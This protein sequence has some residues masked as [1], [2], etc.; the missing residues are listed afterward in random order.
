M[1]DHPFGESP[2]RNAP[3]PLSTALYE[4]YQGGRSGALRV[5][6]EDRPGARIL[7]RRGRV[8][9]VE[10][11]DTSPTAIV[12]LLRRTG[13]L[14]EA[15][16][17]VAQRFARKRGESLDEAAV[18][19]GLVSAGTLNNIREQVQ[20]ETVLDLMLARDVDVDPDWGEGAGAGRELCT[21]PIPFLLKEAQRRASE[22]GPIRRVVPSMETLFVRSA[23]LEGLRES[24]ENLGMSPAE[25]QVYFF[26]DGQRTVEDLATVTCQSRFAVTRALAALIQTG[27]IQQRISTGPVGP[28]RTGRSVLVRIGAMVVATGALVLLVLSLAGST[29]SLWSHAAAQRTFDDPFRT[30]QDEASRARLV[31]AIRLYDLMYRNRPGSFQDL[32]DDGLVAPSDARAAATFA[33]DGDYLLQEAAA[34]SAASPAPPQE[35]DVEDDR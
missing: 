28:A 17:A 14:D 21:L 3:P 16:I 12:D 23:D 31:G 1:N 18:S 30:L 15:G 29:A 27:H 6:R 4:A 13:L 9:L 8:V 5:F 25:R 33:V 20:R 32:L 2:A 22:V 26:V 11:P 35:P 7:V 34:E 10:H 19:A 24:W